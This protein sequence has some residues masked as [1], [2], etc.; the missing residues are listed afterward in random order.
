[1]KINELLTLLNEKMPL[2]LA[3]D[4]DNVGLLV[5]H[6]D[7]NV[8]K[9]YLALDAT[10]Q[11]VDA[12][13]K[14]GAD[15]ILTHHPLIFSGMKRVVDTDITG[16]RVLKLIEHRVA[17]ISMHT[18]YDIAMDC[19]A[20]AAAKKID[21][22]G[23]PLQITDEIEMEDT[24]IK[25]GIGTVGDVDITLEE[26]I[27]DLKEQFFLDYVRVYGKELITS[28][29]RRI[30]ISPGSGKGMYKWAVKQRA[31]VLITGDITHHEGIDAKEAGI[32]VIDAGHFG[33]EKVFLDDMRT[34]LN[35]WLQDKNITV[36]C[37]DEK[38]P[39]EIM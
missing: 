35:Q 31:E 27:T 29:L 34:K 16:R 23:E 4:F 5:G 3:M 2:H 26:L 9:I 39:E 13:I 10:T 7:A 15:L 14:E 22:V 21:L 19:M 1:M 20:W 28:K 18:N 37:H 30:A 38:S 32:C 24:R 12:A 8:K 17:L 11:V 6:T 36:L 33:I 25:L